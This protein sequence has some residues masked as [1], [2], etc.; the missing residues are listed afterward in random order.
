MDGDLAVSA[1][2]QAQPQ[3]MRMVL[4]QVTRNPVPD[5]CPWRAFSDPIVVAVLDLMALTDGDN[6][7]AAV[8]SSLP[9]VV[10][11]GALH[12]R[13]ARNSVERDRRLRENQA[14]EQNGAR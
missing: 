10:Y 2:A 7:A 8:T 13:R 4:E 6:I 11:E 14:R 12:Y 5:I 9:N 1:W 3:A